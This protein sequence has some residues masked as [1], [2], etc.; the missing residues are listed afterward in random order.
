MTGETQNLPEVRVNVIER[1]GTPRKHWINCRIE[2]HV[3]FETDDLASYFFAKWEPI[4]FDLLLLAAAVEFCDRI[5]KRPRMGWGRIICLRLPVHDQAAWKKATVAD[6]LV[7]TLEL[8]TGDYWKIEFVHRR[9]AAPAPPQGML[10]LNEKSAVIPFSEGLDSRAVAG[11]MSKE[12]GTGLVRVRLG[13]KSNDRPK[14]GRGRNAPFT[15]VPYKISAGEYSFPESSARSRGFKF[16]IL[17]GIAAYLANVRRVIVPESGQ[18]ALGPSLVTVGQS[19]E[20]FRN[21][22]AFTSEVSRFLRAILGVTIQYEFPRLWF[23]KAQTLRAYVALPGSDDWKAT[24]SCWQDNRHA[25]IGGK[26]RQCGICAACM[27][28]RLSVHAAGFEE[29]KE[30]YLWEDLNAS[31]LDM[32]APLDHKGTGTTQ[33]QYAIA[34]TLHLDHLAHLRTSPLGSFVIQT[35]VARLVSALKMSTVEVQ[36]RLDNLLLQHNEEWKSFV[37]SLSPESFVRRWVVI[38]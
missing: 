14:D 12:L 27:L 22:P 29:A 4:A 33:R 3:R 20:D 8:L 17:S 30:T 5:K 31:S 1:A 37:N 35:N 15:T 38:R 28:R 9:T 32:A 23:T 10:A 13:T 18:G 19:H 11:L 6:A 36:A 24:R 16:A 7:R 2:S 34:G 26:R 21:H 25:S